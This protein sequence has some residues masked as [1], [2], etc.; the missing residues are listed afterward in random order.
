MLNIGLIGLAVFLSRRVYAV[1]GA[2]GVAS[3]LGYLAY[4]VF[5]DSLLFPFALTLVGVAVVGAGILYQRHSGRI[6]AALECALPLG[7]RSLRPPHARG[8]VGARSI[9][10]GSVRDGREALSQ[11]C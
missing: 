1:F 10:S 9:A 11:F 5:K 2:M 8:A 6:A 7:L 4:R 3:Y